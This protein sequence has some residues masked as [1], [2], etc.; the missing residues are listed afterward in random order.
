MAMKTTVEREGE[1]SGFVKQ[2]RRINS[3]AAHRI[4]NKR[5]RRQTRFARVIPARPPSLTPTFR[6]EYMPGVDPLK[7]KEMMDQEDIENHLRLSAR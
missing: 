1:I 2:R 5:M 7:F 4:I 6:S 3:K